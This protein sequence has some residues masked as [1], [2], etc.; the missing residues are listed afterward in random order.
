MFKKR[1]VLIIEQLDRRFQQLSVMK[2][3]NIPTGGWIRAIRSGLNM[4]LRQL[5][6]RLGT[7]VSS[8]SEM[9]KREV[10]GSITIKKM[11]EVAQALDMKF[12]YGFV[13]NDGSLKALIE[14]RAKE[15]AR[16]IVLRTSQNMKLEDQ[17]NTNSRIER[18]IEERTEE[19]TNE[20]PKL[21][22]D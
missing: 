16:E 14:K 12:V 17:E 22:W 9:E 11:K 4:S 2:S 15:I 5:A 18:A 19:L 6:E 7:N 8:T 10:E 21:L 20:L 13:P 3:V 1:N